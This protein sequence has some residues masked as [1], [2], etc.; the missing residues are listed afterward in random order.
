MRM[1]RFNRLYIVALGLALALAGAVAAQERMLAFRT[2]QVAWQTGPPSLP[3]GAQVTVLAGDL[4]KEG[5]FTIRLKFPAGYQIPAHSHPQIEQVTVLAGT[6][7]IGEG[8]RLEPSRG[9]ALGSGGFVVIPKGHRHYAWTS[10]ETVVQL[11]GTGPW[12]VTYVN[13]ADDPRNR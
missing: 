5:P 3:P 8:D 7:N 6:F 9:T 13:P 1:R 2:D 12:G 10:E 11:N 4:T